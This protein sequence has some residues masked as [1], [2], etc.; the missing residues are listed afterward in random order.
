MIGVKMER[1]IFEHSNSGSGFYCGKMNEKEDITKSTTS[2]LLC[3]SSTKEQKQ[4]NEK[5]TI[6]IEIIIDY[7]HR[8]HIEHH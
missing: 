6:S 3:L 7:Y 8:S 2:S 4:K 5:D 1:N